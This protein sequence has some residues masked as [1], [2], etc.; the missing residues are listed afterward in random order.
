[1]QLSVAW[2][3]VLLQDLCILVPLLFYLTIYQIVARIFSKFLPSFERNPSENCK[4]EGAKA[5]ALTPSSLTFVPRKHPTKVVILSES[6]SYL[7]PK[8]SLTPSLRSRSVR[9]ATAII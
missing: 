2:V 7:K 8:Y 4:N 3:W 1:M 9:N 5:D 6:A